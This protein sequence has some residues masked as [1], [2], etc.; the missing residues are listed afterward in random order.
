MLLSA[1]ADSFALCRYIITLESHVESLQLLEC[2][3]AGKEP[4]ANFDDEP[5]DAFSELFPN[6]IAIMTTYIPCGNVYRYSGFS[7]RLY[8]TVTP[9][10]LLWATSHIRTYIYDEE[11]QQTSVQQILEPSSDGDNT[12][13]RMDGRIPY[14]YVCKCLFLYKHARLVTDDT[15]PP[16][17]LLTLAEKPW[18][19]NSEPD[20]DI[21]MSPLLDIQCLRRDK[22]LAETLQGCAWL[23][24][25]EG[26][27]SQPCAIVYCRAEVVE[28][29]LQTVGVCFRLQ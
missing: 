26:L 12:L 28:P 6:L 8:S 27:A 4:P 24:Q 25:Q 22:N 3:T 29:M 10:N 19:I 7:L 14:R 15:F 16:K 17:A 23:M 18:R 21:A 1:L 2:E 9:A 20:E 5:L 13:D 11:R